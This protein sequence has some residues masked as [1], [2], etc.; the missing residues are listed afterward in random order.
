MLG[1]NKSTKVNAYNFASLPPITLVFRHRPRYIR[2]FLWKT[3]QGAPPEITPH[4]LDF[5]KKSA[6][7]K[8]HFFRTGRNFGDRFLKKGPKSS[9][10]GVP[11]RENFFWQTF[12]KKTPTHQKFWSGPSPSTIYGLYSKKRFGDFSWEMNNFWNF[13]AIYSR[14]HREILKNVFS[15]KGLKISMIEEAPDRNFWWA[16]K[17]LSKVY[18]KTFLGWKSPYR[19][20]GGFISKI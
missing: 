13:W 3:I 17:F 12:D 18:T 4:F 14:N 6:T 16:V 5:S 20:F 10:F 7:Q 19:W 15:K 1:Q 8:T 9:I 2:Q 11:R